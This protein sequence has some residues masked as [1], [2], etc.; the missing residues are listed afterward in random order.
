MSK[1]LMNETNMKKIMLFILLICVGLGAY[2]VNYP[3]YKPSSTNR[4]VYSQPVVQSHVQPI[5]GY[6]TVATG[7][8]TTTDE[9]SAISA[10]GPRRVDYNDSNLPETGYVDGDT[11]TDDQGNTYYWYYGQ[12]NDTPLLIDPG[13]PAPIG[14]PI[15]PMLLFALMAGGA[16]ALRRRQAQA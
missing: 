7:G 2:A 3:T 14:S 16:I 15:L 9:G 4:Q 8:T 13:N 6:S 10:R 11:Y 12:W 5:G 1:K